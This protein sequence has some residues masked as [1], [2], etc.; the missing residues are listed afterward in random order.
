MKRLAALS[1]VMPFLGCYAEGNSEFLWTG[2]QKYFPTLGA[3]EREATSTYQKGGRVFSG[4]ECRRRFLW[5]LLDTKKYYD[6]KRIR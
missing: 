6:G 2:D 1:A 4:F 3:C 5:F